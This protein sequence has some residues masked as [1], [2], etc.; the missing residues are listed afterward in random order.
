MERKFSSG[1]SIKVISFN[2]GSFSI[3]NVYIIVQ[4]GYSSLILSV[5][6][7]NFLLV[8]MMIILL[9]EKRFLQIGPLKLIL[10]LKSFLIMPGSKMFIRTQQMLT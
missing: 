10:F 9:I 2:F 3:K 1:L 8:P 4:R 7:F 6:F 5:Y